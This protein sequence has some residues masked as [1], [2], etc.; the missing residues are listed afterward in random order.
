[1]SGRWRG[2]SLAKAPPAALALLC[3]ILALLS[4]PAAAQVFNGMGDIP[5]RAQ[6]EQIPAALEPPSAVDRRTGTNGPVEQKSTLDEEEIPPFGADLFTGGFRGPRASGLNP[7]YR[8]LPGDRVTL[9]AWG[10]V[11]I[12]QVLP[13]DAQGNIFVPYVGPVHVQG[14]SNSELNARVKAAIQQIFTDNLSVYTNLQ[15]V[16]PVA[17]FVTGYVNK[18]GRYAGNPSDSVLYFLDQASGIDEDTGSF[19]RIHILRHGKTIAAADLYDFLTRGALPRPQFQDGDTIVVEP[20]GPV[21]TVAG[22]VAQAHRYE[23]DGEA[24]LGD[25]LLDLVQLNPGVSQALVTGVREQGPFS[26]YFTLQEFQGSELRAGDD[27]FFTADQ[28]ADA[29]VV[30]IEGSYKGPSRYVVPKDATLKQL[31]NIVPVD[32]ALA[33]VESVSIRRESV[34]ERQHQALEDSLRRLETT[35]LGASSSTAEE[36]RIRVQEAELIQDFVKRAREVEPNGRIVVAH[37]GQVSDIRLQ[38]G[39]VI[40]LPERSDSVLI[41]GEVL[42]PGAMVYTEGRTALDYIERAGGFTEHANRDDVLIIR[43]NGEALP[44]SDVALRSGDEILVLPKAPTKNLQLASTLA[45]ILF[46][47]AITTRVVLGL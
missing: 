38:D 16:Q 39:D 4:A 20:R 23:L 27:I 14:V 15:G 6:A 25:E 8:I 2:V 45:Q 19:R 28:H 18:P 29:I 3:L 34:A 42:V 46:Q 24:Q 30:Q 40:T 10:A 22:D 32:S 47:A 33:A 41:S 11:E 21:V 12:D 9:R 7:T 1:M 44:A 35:Y 36:A 13:V 43:Q 31:L 26:A 37:M 5:S 17:V